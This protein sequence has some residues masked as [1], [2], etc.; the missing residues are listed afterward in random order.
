MVRVENATF[1]YDVADLALYEVLLERE[2]MIIM[3][4]LT[5]EESRSIRAGWMCVVWGFI[6]WG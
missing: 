2:E 1:V 4:K 6:C 5:L 3:K